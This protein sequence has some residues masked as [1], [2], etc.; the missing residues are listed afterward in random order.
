MRSEELVATADLKASS[1][2]LVEEPPENEHYIKINISRGVSIVS[3]SEDETID[4]QSSSQTV[5]ES[6]RYFS[7]KVKNI[8]ELNEEDELN[9]ETDD[10]D[11]EISSKNESTKDSF[12]RSRSKID[13]NLMNA[14]NKRL[15]SMSE[16]ETELITS[17]A[18][19]RKSSV[20]VE[21]SN[22]SEEGPTPV[23]AADAHD[24]KF[25]EVER[26]S[27]LRTSSR[28]EGSAKKV[29]KVVSFDEHPLEIQRESNDNDDAVEELFR[30]IQAQRNILGEILE[31]QEEAKKDE[32]KNRGLGRRRESISP[33]RRSSFEALRKKSQDE[34][35]RDSALDSEGTNSEKVELSGQEALVDATK[36]RPSES[37]STDGGLLVKRE[38]DT[39]D[40]RDSQST[41][42]NG[43]RADSN[44]LSAFSSSV[45][46]KVPDLSGD[47]TDNI[48][49][50]GQSQSENCTG[51]VK[52]VKK[53]SFESHSMNDELSIQQKPDGLE[54]RD[55]RLEEN[56][57]S[58]ADS[59]NTVQNQ[60]P[61]SPR[62]SISKQQPENDLKPIRIRSR[63]GS[64][65]TEVDGQSEKQQPDL[66]STRIRSRTGSLLE[67]DGDQ[68]E[69]KQPEKH[70]TPSR[71]RSRSGSLLEDGDGQFEKQQPDSKSPRTRSRTGSL[72]E[73]GGDQ[74]EKQQPE[75]DSKPIRIRSRT[76]SLLEDS[77]D[78]SEKH[79]VDKDSKR[80]RIRNRTGSLL[81]EDADQFEKQQLE[82][83]SK[84]TRTR[85]RTG[86]LLEDGTDQSEKEQPEKDAKLSRTRSRT[87]SLLENDADQ[88]KQPEKDSKP[89]RVRS[90][91]GSFLENDADQSKQPEKDSKPTRVRSRTGSLLENDADQSKQ[92][93]KDSKPSRTGSLFQD[94]ADQ[95]EKQQ[96]EKDSKPSR[97][98]SRTGSFLENGID[99]SKQPEKDSKPIRTRSRTGSLLEDGTDQSEKQQ[100]EKD[101]KPTRTRSR[102]GSLLEN[103]A[104]QS[105]QLEKDSKP[106]RTRSRTG[107]ILENDA[108]QS[109]QPEKDSKPTRTR[110][111]TGSLLDNDTDQSK[112]PE[113]DSKLSRTG[114]LLENGD[115]QSRKGSLVGPDAGSDLRNRIRPK[116]SG[117][118][119]FS[120]KS[121][122]IDG[123]NVGQ[124]GPEE[125]SNAAKIPSEDGN[126]DERTSGEEPKQKQN[127]AG[128]GSEQPD[129]SKIREPK[130][131]DLLAKKADVDRFLP[132]EIDQSRKKATDSRRGSELIGKEGRPEDFGSKNQPKADGTSVSEMDKGK[133]ADDVPGSQQAESGISKGKPEKARG[134]FDFGGSRRGSKLLGEGSENNSKSVNQLEPEKASV[135]E[136]DKGK[137]SDLPT[138]ANS[139]P[140]S[141]QVE[142]DISKA[143]PEK[144][145]KSFDSGDSRR[146][147]KSLG[148]EEIGNSKSKPTKVSRSNSRSSTK[149]ESENNLAER[150]GSKSEVPSRIES[151]KDTG[152]R[153][154]SIEYADS[155]RKSLTD[156]VRILGDKSEEP[157]SADSISLKESEPQKLDENKR[158]LPRGST[159]RSSTLESVSD[160]SFDDENK[161]LAS[162]RNSLVAGQKSEDKRGNRILGITNLPLLFLL[163]SE[164]F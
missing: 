70:S 6:A 74:Y 156:S 4:E 7:K 144:A 103:D 27:A 154:S 101:S 147:S 104:D 32:A 72:L 60:I 56:D 23:A 3:V 76:G 75:K 55:T 20:I 46:D 31:K 99:Q 89:T 92:P 36:R 114:S 97:T 82:K 71:I 130:E 9:L 94:S 84:P 40:R 138:G 33:T 126:I 1:F 66:K 2:G 164:R 81:E 109:K 13:E 69:K 78:Q 127:D 85:S 98:R 93:E 51:N 143:K 128:Y 134:S 37:N 140:A 8:Y 139:T 26:K 15:S 158:K 142:S 59:S 108:D 106:T 124:I 113:K 102:T 91:T 19:S 22:I 119:S 49:K 146:G 68:S 63:T 152:S 133:K 105:K 161:N 54:P 117:T 111:R 131:A 67:D 79:Q 148:K 141:Q 95:S 121:T 47:S 80:A 52:L 155:P 57:S 129:D 42:T 86:S 64:L 107:S 122:S 160:L 10:G 137:A 116:L 61:E 118:D 44:E 12:F 62:D 163:F 48:K 149:S 136:M 150:P 58:G 29:C 90:R 39:L 112:Q 16:N 132:Q 24:Q 96:P 14:I 157:E 125:R 115:D 100:S 135:L 73:D 35:R 5:E 159:I 43:L 53:K 18:V 162:K 83:D 38:R 50:F 77:G 120:S 25:S 45:C 34:P 123:T 65:L 110:S 28:D 151:D 87:G 21:R 17:H 11:S 30:R 153:K 41:E 145:R 88:S